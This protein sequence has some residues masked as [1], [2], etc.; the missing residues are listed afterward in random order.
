MCSKIIPKDMQSVDTYGMTVTDG[1]SRF[2]FYTCH[3]SNEC[4]QDFKQ[5]YYDPDSPSTRALI[6][7]MV[8]MANGAA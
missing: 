1:D 4:R 5:K 7:N 3:C 6:R 2:H 8:A